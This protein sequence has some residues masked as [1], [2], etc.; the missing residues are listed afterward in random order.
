M[1]RSLKPESDNK[2]KLQS[3]DYFRQRVA[4]LRSINIIESQTWAPQIV[5]REETCNERL[6]TQPFSELFFSSYFINKETIHSS[7]PQKLSTLFAYEL[8]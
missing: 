5:M 3:K 7:R 2:N 6:S 8:L 4:T 1:V